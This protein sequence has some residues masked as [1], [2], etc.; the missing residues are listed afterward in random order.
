MNHNIDRWSKIAAHFPGRTDN[1]IKNH[2]NTRI[3]KRLKQLGVD[4]VTHMPIQQTNQLQPSSSSSKGSQQN[5][6]IMKSLDSTE[7]EKREDNKVAWDGTTSDIINN[8]EMLLCSELDL[9]S[10][11]SQETNTSASSFS[12]SSSSFSQ[13]DDSSHLSMGESSYLQP[14]SLTQWVDSICCMDSI[15]AWDGFSPLE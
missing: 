15:L 10:W 8:N 9:G 3:K 14:N 11:M 1:E 6:E 12:Y 13:L 7:E 2:W 5:V 4:P